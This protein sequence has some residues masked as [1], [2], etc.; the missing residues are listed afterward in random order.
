M[1]HRLAGSADAQILGELNY[2]L[3]RDEGHRNRM[4]IPELVTRMEGLLAGGYR[5][6]IF[7]DA[8]GVLAYALYREET[9]HIYLRQFFVQ[10]QH[11]RS[12]VGRRCFEMLVSEIWP[13][14]KR[15]TVNVL[16]H[17]QAGI[18]F[19]RAVGFNDYCLTLERKGEQ[20]TH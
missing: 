3:I 8:T 2:Q 12:G 7:E 15:I 4:T 11:R 16:C 17:N 20:R 19:W 5:A 18:A 6:S 1:R 10:R 14:N 13:K 9:D